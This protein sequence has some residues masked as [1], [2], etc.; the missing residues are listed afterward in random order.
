MTID[1]P[2]EDHK[3]LKTIAALNSKPMKDIIV[4]ALGMFYK[5][6]EHIPNTET[7]KV[8]DEI[9]SGKGLVKCESVDDLFKK[10]GI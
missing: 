7:R 2:I 8:L 1:L 10:L 4:E 9:K 5:T 6:Q 3:R